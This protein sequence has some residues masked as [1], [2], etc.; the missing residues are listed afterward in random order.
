MHGETGCVN[1]VLI[2]LKLTYSVVYK[3]FI[4]DKVVILS[5]LKIF[6]NA[7]MILNKMRKFWRPTY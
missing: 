2:G 1:S 3:S 6:V 4:G 7:N 5:I